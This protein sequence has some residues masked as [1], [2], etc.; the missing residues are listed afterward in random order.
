MLAKRAG[1]GDKASP[2]ALRHSFATSL[3]ARTNDVALL[4]KALGHRSI[5]SSMVY[6][7]LPDERLRQALR[8]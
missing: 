6:V 3:L 1:I 4:Q 2:H 8:S 7:R 5:A